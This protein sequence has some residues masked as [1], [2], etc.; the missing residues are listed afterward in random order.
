MEEK[1]LTIN[2]AAEFIGI[3]RTTLYRYAK[4]N[5]PKIIIYKKGARSVV[6]ESDVIRLKDELEKLTP[7]YKQPE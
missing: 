3:D 1:T 6:K 5:P 4:Q 2:E 7:L